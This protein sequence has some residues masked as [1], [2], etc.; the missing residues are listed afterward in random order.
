MHSEESQSGPSDRSE[1]SVPHC[2]RPSMI[3]CQLVP[4]NK[5]NI[6]CQLGFT[7]SYLS[8]PFHSLQKEVKTKYIRYV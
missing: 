4:E 6:Q 3:H 2:P 8:L 7:G 5:Q 1:F